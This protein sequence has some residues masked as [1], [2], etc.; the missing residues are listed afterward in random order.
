MNFFRLAAFGCIFAFATFNASAQFL[1][2][3]FLMKDAHQ[4]M[5][6][7]PALAPDRGY[8]DIPV[9]GNFNLNVNSN[10]LGFQDALDAFSGDTDGNYLS[11]Q[12]INGLKDV[13]RASFG[14]G[15]DALSAGWWKGDNFWSVNVGTRFDLGVEIP[16][17]MFEF[18]R[19]LDNIDDI[20]WGNYR[21]DIGK[22]RFSLNIFS[23]IGVGLTRELTEKL[24]VG[25]KVKLILGMGRIDLN[26]D[27][28]SLATSNLEGDVLKQEGWANGGTASLAVKASL[29]SSLAGMELHE[30]KNGYIDDFT[31]NG[32][33]IAGYGGAVDFGVAYKALDNLTLSASVNDLGF[34]T[35]GSGSSD[36]FSAETNRYFSEENYEEFVDIVDNEDLLNYNLFGFKHDKASSSRTTSLY[37]NFTIGG[38]YTFVDDIFAVGL[39]STT[40][41]LKPA[42]LT[43]ITLSGA[44]RPNNNINFALSYSVIQ[45]AGRTIGLGAKLGPFFI[46]TDYLYLGSSSKVFNA[47]AGISIPLSSRD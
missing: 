24:T 31:Y 25:G 8:I 20:D 19:E 2:T 1:R 32:F 15:F 43:E 9:V 23:E 14:L 35:W 13:N 37:S 22:E 45:S 42:T 11:D 30:D 39:L 5:K 40:R 47:Y 6:I 27:E 44:V 7:N 17:S 3:S 12:F 10:A 36:V 33:G 28:I 4:R 34:I 21:M 26:I 38:E 29:E 41:V 16:R 46:G 18:I